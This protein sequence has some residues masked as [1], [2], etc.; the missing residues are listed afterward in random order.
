MEIPPNRV[1][2]LPPFSRSCVCEGERDGVQLFVQAPGRRTKW[3]RA[4]VRTGQRLNGWSGNPRDLQTLEPGEI[5]NVAEQS[6]RTFLYGQVHTSASL[7]VLT[8][9]RNAGLLRHRHLVT[10][11]LARLQ[12]GRN[13]GLGDTAK[14]KA[15]CQDFFV[16][17]KDAD[18]DVP[19]LKE[20]NRS[21]AAR[22]SCARNFLGFLLSRIFRSRSGIETVSI[23]PGQVTAGGDFDLDIGFGSHDRA[24]R[25]DFEIDQ[26]S[27]PT[28]PQTGTGLAVFNP[29]IVVGCG[30]AES[31]ELAIEGIAPFQDLRKGK[32][33]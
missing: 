2:T 24:H 1:G 17:W 26:G 27:V 5:Q 13:Y 14:A 9:F 28:D 29:D 6:R 10:G 31:A 11:V 22:T 16:F 32:L 20:A 15:G 12:I 19:I 21:S 25:P 23:F 8:R 33:I 3:S 7:I 18:P 30:V 4:L